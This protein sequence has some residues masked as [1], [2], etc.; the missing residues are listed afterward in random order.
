M[1]T[2]G[3]EDRSAEGVVVSRP[4]LTGGRLALEAIKAP[5]VAAQLVHRLHQER[6]PGWPEQGV[7][8][9]KASVVAEDDVQ[10]HL[11]ERRREARICL[12]ARRTVWWP[13]GIPPRSLP[14]SFRLTPQAS[15]ELASS[16]PI[17]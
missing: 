10:Q 6:L 8:V 2:N 16:L 17:P 7:T 3:Y 9:L 13:L 5:E 12:I 14:E 15:P 4:L 11:A 1:S